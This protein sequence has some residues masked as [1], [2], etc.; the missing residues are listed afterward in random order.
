MNDGP[1]RIRAKAAA[2]LSALLLV[3][4]AACSG[5]GLRLGVRQG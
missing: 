2:M 3:M 5:G 1:V 4:V